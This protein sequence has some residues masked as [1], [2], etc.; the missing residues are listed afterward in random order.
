MADMEQMNQDV[1]EKIPDLVENLYTKFWFSD[2]VDVTGNLEQNPGILAFHGIIFPLVTFLATA[3]L[4]VA[5]VRLLW[6]RRLDPMMDTVKALLTLVFVT[7]VGL[8]VTQLLVDFSNQLS[9]Y[10]LARP[11]VGDTFR[12]LGDLLGDSTVLDALLGPASALVGV[13]LGIAVIVGLVI[14]I[15]AL[16]YT[17]GVI[18]I[19]A[20]ALPLAAAAAL[21]PGPGT[22]IFTRVTGWMAGSILFKPVISIIYALGFILMGQAGQ[23]SGY[24]EGDGGIVFVSDNNGGGDDGAVFQYLVGVAIITMAT[25]ALPLLWSVLSK[26][27]SGLTAKLGANMLGGGGGGGGFGGNGGGNGGNGNRNNGNRATPSSYD[28]AASSMGGDASTRAAA[29]SNG[30]PSPEMAG[31]GGSGGSTLAAGASSGSGSSSFGTPSSGMTAEAASASA[32]GSASGTGTSGSGANGS[33]TR[34]AAGGSGG[35]SGGGTVLPAG[36]G[37]VSS[38]GAGTG[39]GGG[40]GGGDASGAMPT[41]AG[42]GGGAGTTGGPGGGDD[43]HVMPTGA[44]DGGDTGG[45]GGGPIATGAASAAGGGGYPGG[46]GGTSG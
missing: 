22:S 17:Q 33:A 10:I 20:A 6:Y 27:F 14:Q 12:N 19:C 39:S 36:A 41:G 5:A 2:F 16:F 3:G 37:S 43:G 34:T 24:T 25:G 38:L 1:S 28:G 11:E 32:Q 7:F 44:G 31:V 45:T 26:M 13:L 40:P 35:T 9:F 29:I 8:F 15:V 21:I 18:Y 23:G 4:L 30:L 42:D 46:G